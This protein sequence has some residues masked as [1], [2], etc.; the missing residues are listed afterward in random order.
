MVSIVHAKLATS[1][2]VNFDLESKLHLVPLLL[3]FD[4]LCFMVLV[5][6]FPCAC[7]INAQKLL[8]RK[9]LTKE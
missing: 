2:I 3:I 4:A 5:H 1:L 6:S 9:F 7:L 8:K